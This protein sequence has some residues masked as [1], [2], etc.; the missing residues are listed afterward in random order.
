MRFKRCR[1][2]IFVVT[3]VVAQGDVSVRFKHSVTSISFEP[4]R[5]R[6][7]S[8]AL[9]TMPPSSEWHVKGRKAY[10]IFG[11]VLTITDLDKQEVTLIDPENKRFAIFAGDAYI[12]ALSEA[13]ALEMPA[14]AHRLID[15]MKM[16]ITSQRTGRSEAIQGILADEEE[17]VLSF[18]M[19]MPANAPPG[20]P[21]IQTRVVMNTWTAKADELLRLPALR[22]LAGFAF[23]TELVM[24]RNAAMRQRT[25]SFPEHSQWRDI[26]QESLRKPAVVLRTRVAM[27]AP[28]VAAMV[29]EKKCRL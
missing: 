4:G 19:T 22:E 2:A 21:E 28:G 18:G 13:L 23:V 10:S 24:N 5:E 3:A 12:Q 9:S 11:N 26:Q 1:V 20:I 29:R 7:G 25:I 17:V 14:D 8:P 16:E 15:G 27:Y 6:A